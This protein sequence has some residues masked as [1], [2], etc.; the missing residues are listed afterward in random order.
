[1]DLFAPHRDAPLGVDALAHTWPHEL[2][3]AF[4]PLALVPPTLSRV[5][6]C[7]HMLVLIALH[8]PAMHWL[9]EIYQMLCAQPW[10]LP[11]HRDLLSQG[12]G[13]IFYQHPVCLALWAWP[14]SDLI[15]RRWDCHSM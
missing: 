10:Q 11:L 6:E 12:V 4:P 7:G 3:H 2:P 8:W 9:A 14:L 15:T 5:R 13:V 1:M